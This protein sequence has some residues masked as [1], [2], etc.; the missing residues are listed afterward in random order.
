MS[1]LEVLEKTGTEA[2]K[3]L[4][5]QKLAAG[6]PFMINSKDLPA[7]QSYLEYPDSS[8]NIVTIA[9]DLHSFNIVRKLSTS[10]A[11]S[12]RHQYNLQ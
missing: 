6:K 9:P 4:R 8:I 12:V 3:Q 5:K 7:T 10:E 2:V 11:Q 1:D